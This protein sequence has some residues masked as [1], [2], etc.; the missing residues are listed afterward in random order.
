[1]TD[2]FKLFFFPPPNATHEQL[3]CPSPNHWRPLEFH[4]L[5]F[6]GEE[7]RG[8]NISR[9]ICESFQTPP[10]CPQATP[11]WRHCVCVCPYG[12]C[13]RDKLPSFLWGQDTWKQFVSCHLLFPHLLGNLFEHLK[14]SLANN[15]SWQYYSWWEWVPNHQ[16]LQKNRSP[17]M[18]GDVFSVTTPTLC[19]KTSPR[20]A[21]RVQ[22]KCG[23]ENTQ[24]VC[25]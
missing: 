12:I 9:L 8:V 1:M 14:L 24:P 23:E 4:Y 25:F 18:S 15:F 3:C 20:A 7:K 17:D 16:D 10:E 13:H 11:R 19:I 5:H 6:W 2:S 22:Q 21:P